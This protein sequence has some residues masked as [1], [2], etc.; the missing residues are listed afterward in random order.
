MIARVDLGVVEF[1]LE[2]PTTALLDNSLEEAV[3]GAHRRAAVKA[4]AELETLLAGTRQCP[5]CG[6]C[7]DMA[8][9]LEPVMPKGRHSLAL[10]ERGLYLV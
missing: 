2:S 9:P 8:R 5:G 1:D 6:R 4:H 7:G 3:L 10:V